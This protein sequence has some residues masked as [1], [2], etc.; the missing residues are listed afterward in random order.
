MKKLFVAMALAGATVLGALSGV[1]TVQAGNCGPRIC[2]ELYAPVVCSNG[3]TYPNQCY[4][5]RACATGCV[6]TGVF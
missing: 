2:P 4:A 6:S 1:D 5:N 3:K